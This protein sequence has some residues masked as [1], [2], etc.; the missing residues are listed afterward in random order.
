MELGS[1]PQIISSSMFS[2]LH[3]SMLSTLWLREVL[4]TKLSWCALSM[5]SQFLMLSGTRTACS[6][7]WGGTTSPARTTRGTSWQFPRWERRTLPTTLARHQTALA[8]PED[9][10]SSEVNYYSTNNHSYNS[11]P[12]PG[13]P[14][15][16]LFNSR[17][18]YVSKDS[19]RVSWYTTSYQQI[20]QYRLAW[21]QSGVC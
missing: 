18:E 13:N 16:P 7:T 20:L 3:M 5:L 19:Y 4:G 9:R 11:C 12:P 10:Y 8:S 14:A 21:K 6:W 15:P 17:V 2:M 1:Q